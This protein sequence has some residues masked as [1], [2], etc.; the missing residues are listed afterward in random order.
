MKCDTYVVKLDTTI[1]VSCNGKAIWKMPS[2]SG[3]LQMLTEFERWLEETNPDAK[4][5]KERC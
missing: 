5:R 2:N 3:N 4:I 1:T